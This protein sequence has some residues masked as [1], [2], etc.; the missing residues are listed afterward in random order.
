MTKDEL[1]EVWGG[2]KPHKEIYIKSIPFDAH[3]V[4]SDF[5]ADRQIMCSFMCKKGRL[6]TLLGLLRR[7][8]HRA[9]IS[10]RQA[11]A[12]MLIGAK[13]WCFLWAMTFGMLRS[14]RPGEETKRW[15]YLGERGRDRAQRALSLKR[16]CDVLLTFF[17]LAWFF[18]HSTEA[19]STSS[20]FMSWMKLGIGN[21]TMITLG[22]T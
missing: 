1:G 9:A 22:N 16:G 17:Q 8:R 11:M 14:S 18:G 3:M 7:H 19:F 13:S 21:R 5:A 12:T 4:S 10:S 15:K 6:K 20:I 2:F